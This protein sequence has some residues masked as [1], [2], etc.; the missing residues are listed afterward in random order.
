VLVRQHDRFRERLALEDLDDALEAEVRRQACVAF[1]TLG[2]EGLARV[3]FFTD[4]MGTVMINEVNTMPGFTPISM[5]PRMWGAS[6]LA[7]ADLV[8]HLVRDA[9]RR[10][11]GLR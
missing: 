7:Y 4:R 6:G 9:Q 8:S 1:E 5:F 3:D 10:G 2:C 11:T